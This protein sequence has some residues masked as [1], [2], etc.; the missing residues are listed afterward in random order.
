VS[1][2]K[3]YLVG[4]NSVPF[5]VAGDAPQ[6]LTARLSP[7][8]MTQYFA[9]RAAQG[10]NSAWVNLLCNTYTGGNADGSTYDGIA[11]FT[12]TTGDGRADLSKPNP[13]FFA[14]VDAAVSAAAAAKIVLFLDPIET[15]GFLPTLQSNGLTAGRAYGQFLGLRYLAAN[16]IVWMSGNDFRA[17]QSTSD[18]ALVH[19]VA[20]GIK[21]KDT[22][23]LQTVELD[24]PTYMSS[25]DD[26]LWV[27]SIDLNLTYTYYPSYAQLYVDD[28]RTNHL[29]NIMVEANY[30]GENM[31]GGTHLTNA[32]DIRTQ[33]YW[34]NLS[35]ATGS[36]YG[37]HWEVFLMASSTWKANFATDQGAPQIAYVQSLFMSR[38]WYRL[39]PDQTNTVVLSGFGTFSASGSAQDNTYATTARTADGTLVMTYIPTARPF[40]VDMTKLAASA[41]ARWYDPTTGAYTTVSGSPL[42]NAGR[43]TFTPPTAKHADGYD[44]WV[45][46]LETSPPP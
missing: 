8:D 38:A 20:L 2:D 46:V 12:G 18:D 39:V 36:F 42:A 26:A 19:E 4:A 40:D 37:N 7:T 32:H 16:N 30:E 44:D 31:Q 5:L 23:H 17:W 13:A 33:Y 1:A 27:P 14:R 41:V 34:S 3:R 6:C 43:K 45:L 25:L 24:Y 15:G 9:M 22:R 21:D 10:F 29:P 28:N 11:P 35:G